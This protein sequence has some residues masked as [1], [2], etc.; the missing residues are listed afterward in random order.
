[1]TLLGVISLLSVMLVLAAIPSTSVALVVTRSV[2]LGFANG[3]AVAFGIVLG[4]L[5]FVTLA[6]LGMS[7]LAETMGVFFAILKYAGGAYLIWLGVT[8]ICSTSKV[9]FRKA[10]TRKLSLLASLLS[11]FVLTLGD[12]KAILFYASLFPTFVDMAS[13]SP[14]DVAAIILI[15]ILAVGS[16]KLAYAFA[17]QRI[18]QHFQN[19]RTQK[20]TGS[21]AGCFMIGA[22]TYLIAKA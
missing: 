19:R 14:Q 9:D 1:M 4:D 17:A 3:A 15:T 6:I 10:D 5:V 18:V 21:V 7:V 12:V 13:L 20:I 11:G 22:G 16:V 8:L 2:T